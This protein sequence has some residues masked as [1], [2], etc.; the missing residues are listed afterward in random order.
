[1]DRQ[2]LSFLELLSEPKKLEWKGRKESRN[3]KLIMTLVLYTNRF[4]STQAGW[5]GRGSNLAPA[6]VACLSNILSWS[7]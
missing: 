1:M 6:C 7:L 2:T 5:A 3:E 4:R